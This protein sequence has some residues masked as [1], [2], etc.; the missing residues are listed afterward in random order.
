MLRNS[1][2]IYVFL[3]FIAATGIFIPHASSGYQVSGLLEFTY[4]IDETKAGD[5]PSN[6][7]NNF[8]QYYSV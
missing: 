2:K 1:L 4:N 8:S 5:N 3:I 6:R 7:R